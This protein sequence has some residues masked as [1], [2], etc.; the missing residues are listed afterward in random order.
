MRGSHH[1]FIG[2][3][4]VDLLSMTGLADR[5]GRATIRLPMPSPYRDIVGS[6]AWDALPRVLHDLHERGGDGT[7]VVTARGIA[8]LFT[9]LGYAPSEGNAPATLRIERTD[10]GERWIRT[11]RDEVFT[12]EQRVVRGSIHERFGPFELQFKVTVRGGNALLYEAMALRLFGVKIPSPRLEASER[13][14]GPRVHVSVGVGK[15]FRYTG[16]IVPR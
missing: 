16:F 11:F 2:A 12:T 1:H 10:D 4:A 7:L 9:F 13:A 6:A 14:D 15:S 5:T 8:R 3:R